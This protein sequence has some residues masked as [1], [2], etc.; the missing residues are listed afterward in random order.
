MSSKT[1]E[2]HEARREAR[3]NERAA[4]PQVIKE[5][6]RP[7]MH[8]GSETGSF[9]FL[10]HEAC[11]IRGGILY[12]REPANITLTILG[13]DGSSFVAPMFEG[14]VGYN[15]L[16]PAPVVLKAGDRISAVS[17][18]ETAHLMYSFTYLVR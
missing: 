13:K 15:D 12:L 18:V 2:A 4:Q 3:R 6:V 8:S 10:V 11:I 14:K 7:A 5:Q 1:V 17:D 9:E 16:F